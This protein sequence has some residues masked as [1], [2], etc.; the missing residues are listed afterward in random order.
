MRYKLRCIRVDEAGKWLCRKSFTLK[1]SIAVLLAVT[2]KLTSALLNQPQ[3]DNVF[4]EAC[5]F[6]VAAFVSNVNLKCLVVYN[7]VCKL[8]AEE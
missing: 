2:G 4:E 7:R 1:V 5:G 6:T 8:S 3:T